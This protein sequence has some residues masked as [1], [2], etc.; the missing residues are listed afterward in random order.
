MLFF[1]Q[2]WCHYFFSWYRKEPGK[3]N[4]SLV[5][6]AWEFPRDDCEWICVIRHTPY[7]LQFVF[8]AKIEGKAWNSEWRAQRQL[9][10]KEGGSGESE[11]QEMALSMV[12]GNGTGKYTASYSFVPFPKPLCGFFL[13][14]CL[15]GFLFVVGLLLLLLLLWVFF[16]LFVFSFPVRQSKTCLMLSR[17]W[18]IHLLF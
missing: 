9:P 13:F 15:L 5:T 4:P 12:C 16:C 18:R 3:C 2:T 10:K 17:K 1:A 7:L 8:H 14:V 6:R 11:E